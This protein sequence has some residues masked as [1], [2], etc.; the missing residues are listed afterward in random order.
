MQSH[1][2]YD[3]MVGPGLQLKGLSLSL[4]AMTASYTR[5]GQKMYRSRQALAEFF[6]YSERQVGTALQSLVNDGLLMR[7]EGRGG[8]RTYT[9]HE[10]G[11]REKLKGTETLSSFEHFLKHSKPCSRGEIISSP[12]RKKFPAK[13][14]E[15]T[16]LYGKILP[17]KQE[18]SSSH[19]INNNYTSKPIYIN[20][21]AATPEEDLVKLIMFVFFFKNNCSPQHEAKAFVDY[22]KERDWRLSGGKVIDNIQELVLT[23][24]SWTVKTPIDT[25][26]RNNF[27]KGW[28]EVYKIVPHYLKY[29]VVN[30]RMRIQTPTSA[31]IVC[32]RGLAAWLRE[33][34]NKVE[35]IFRR[36]SSSNYQIHW[37]A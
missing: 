20:D 21:V 14:E 6:G 7:D 26:R 18:E 29:D 17:V 3:W 30:I 15:S 9:I 2:T 31:H 35:D 32:S 22:Y 5:N 11:I 24:H 27:M 25:G 16:C 8:H 33:N 36:C 19:N 23:A 12:N 37:S 28:G 4:F 34:R 1:L 10:A 13:Q